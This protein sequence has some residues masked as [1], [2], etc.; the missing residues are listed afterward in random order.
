MSEQQ[1]SSEPSASIQSVLLIGSNGFLGKTIPDRIVTRHPHCKVTLLDIAPKSALDYP[2]HRG[3]ITNLSSLLEIFDKVKPQ[4]VIHSATPPI[5]TV[6]QGSEKLYF[7]VNVEGTRNVIKACNE[8]GVTALVYTSSASVIYDGGDLINANEKQ[9]YATKHV[10][11]YN[12]SKVLPVY[13]CPSLHSIRHMP[14]DWFSRPI[15]PLFIL[16]PFAHQPCSGPATGLSYPGCI[17]SSKIARR[18]GK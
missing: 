13:I 14:I 6:G 12:A 1:R 18:C 16:V 8:T 5:T 2:Y 10:D 4:V 17:M 3:D 9:P 11:A 15:L 7:S